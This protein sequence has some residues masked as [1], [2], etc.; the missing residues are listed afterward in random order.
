MSNMSKMNGFARGIAV[1]AVAAAAIGIITA[2]KTRH[3]R[4]AASKFIRTAGDI[5]ED[6]SN[7]WR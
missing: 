6:V 1:G 2:P 5:V 3:F 7:L 4:T